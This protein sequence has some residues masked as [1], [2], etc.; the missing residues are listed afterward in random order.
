MRHP[1]FEGLVPRIVAAGIG[2]M[3]YDFPYMQVGS[4]RPDPAPVLEASVRKAIDEA[5]ELAA[6]EKVIAGGKSMGGRMTSQALAKQHDERVNGIVFLGFPLHRPR[7]PSTARAQ[8]LHDVQV[9]MLFLQGTRDALANL[10]LMKE[11]C[12]SIGPRATLHVID[13]ADHSF[14]VLKR[15]GRT[16][17]DVY[18]EMATAISAWTTSL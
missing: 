4:R 7:Q 17:E 8:H 9:P 3:R 2:V 10:D 18:C 14:A 1:F 16:E 6:G 11:V 12:D 5:W 13:T 15:S